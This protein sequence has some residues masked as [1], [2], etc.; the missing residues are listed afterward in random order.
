MQQRLAERAVEVDGDLV[1][2]EALK[3]IT[4]P[5]TIGTR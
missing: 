4:T 3:L 2:A 1:V 5:T